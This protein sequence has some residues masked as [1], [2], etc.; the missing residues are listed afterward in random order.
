MSRLPFCATETHATRW[1]GRADRDVSAGA[2]R[3]VRHP[4]LRT[5]SGAVSLQTPNSAPDTAARNSRRS[6][7][8]AMTLGMTSPQVLGC[9]ASGE[10]G[11]G[12]IHQI[13]ERG[14]F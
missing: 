8:S 2:S 7:S 6:S 3:F 9:F 4:L 5:A 1:V 12:Q 13:D 10:P 14:A 11:G